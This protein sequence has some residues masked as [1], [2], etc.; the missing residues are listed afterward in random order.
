MKAKARKASARSTLSFSKESEAVCDIGLD[1]HPPEAG[2][3]IGHLTD[4]LYVG[5]ARQFSLP[6][7]QGENCSAAAARSA[8]TVNQ[9][10]ALTRTSQLP[11]NSEP[12]A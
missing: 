6:F 4:G 7:A 11:D 5:I 2:R 12:F 10:G 3:P 9:R 1:H 8:S